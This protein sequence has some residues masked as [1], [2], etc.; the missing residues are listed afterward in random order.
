[1][2]KKTV[3]A[4]EHFTIQE[5]TYGFQD[6]LPNELPNNEQDIPTTGLFFSTPVAQVNVIGTYRMF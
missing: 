1:M 2:L 3:N 6:H 4:D 5:N